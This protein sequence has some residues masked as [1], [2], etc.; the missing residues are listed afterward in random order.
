MTANICPP[1][2][3]ETSVAENFDAYH[4]W[5]GIPP[6][7]QPP[8][9]YRLLALELFESDPN[10]IES[11]ADRQMGHLRTYQTGKHA[12]LSQRLLDE[13]AAAQGLPFES[14]EERQPTTPNYGSDWRQRRHRR[15][16]PTAGWSRAEWALIRRWPG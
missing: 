1:H 7:D 4:R 13:V 2:V 12:D 11:A 8:N 15:R 5:L 16:A 3:A 14:A 10:V 6:K 9:H